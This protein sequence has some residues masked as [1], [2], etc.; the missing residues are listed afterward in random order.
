LQRTHLE[1]RAAAHAGFVDGRV[2]GGDHG[3]EGRLVD[4]AL[5]VATRPTYVYSGC[6]S[7]C[8]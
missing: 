8:R 2:A 3:R 5:V 4:G 1:A 6:M 7:Y